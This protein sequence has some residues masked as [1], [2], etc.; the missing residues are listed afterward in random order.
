MNL[1]SASSILIISALL[2]LKIA[3]KYKIIDRP[4]FR[5][6][7]NE[8][9]IR[10]AGILFYIS[11]VVFF[12]FSGFKYPFFFLG[13]TLISIVSF[14]DDLKTLSSKLRLIIQFISISII[15]YQIT[16]ITEITLIYLPLLLITGVG[17]INVYNFMDGINGMTGMYSLVCFSGLY[18]INYS[19]NIIDERILVYTIISI[20]IFGFFNFRKK[21]RFFC[22]DIGSISVSTILFFI[23]TLFMIKLKAPLLLLVVGVYA[24]DSILTIVYRKY[25]GEN[26]MSPHRHH[27]YQKLTDISNFHHLKTSFIYALLQSFIFV[28]VF[29]NYKKEIMIQLILLLVISSLLVLLYIVLFKRLSL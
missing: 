13:L 1:L 8:P 23:V 26:I 2:Y 19:E 22:G 14:I 5:S 21:A 10:G 25:I 24:V 7:H 16:G 11:A 4:N 27:I 18:L 15:I 28:I 20:L 3:Q 17:F 9:I 12:F 29:L 6:S